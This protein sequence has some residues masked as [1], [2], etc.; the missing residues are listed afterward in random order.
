MFTTTALEEC[1]PFF[2]LWHVVAICP[3]ETCQGKYKL[4]TLITGKSDSF[5]TLY[6]GKQQPNGFKSQ[7]NVFT[8]D[9]SH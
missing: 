8:N 4:L 3:G 7:V 5:C 6:Q 2:G 1:C 9:F